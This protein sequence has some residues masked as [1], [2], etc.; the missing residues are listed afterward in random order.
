MPPMSCLPFNH[1][2]SLSLPLSH[3]GATK[4]F[5]YSRLSFWLSCARMSLVEV[6]WL[7]EKWDG[8]CFFIHVH[9]HMQ[10]KE[11]INALISSI[12]PWHTNWVVFTNFPMI[13]LLLFF[14]HFQPPFFLHL[15]VSPIRVQCV[16][17]FS[18]TDATIEW[19]S[20]FDTNLIEC[21]RCYYVML[22]CVLLFYISTLFCSFFF[23]RN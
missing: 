19:K 22:C 14:F 16:M 5:S 10:W 18:I 7:N 23:I 13:C 11:R 21:Q 2:T 6:M 8:S 9:V 1:W 17:L 3:F 12:S 4:S 15:F 20:D